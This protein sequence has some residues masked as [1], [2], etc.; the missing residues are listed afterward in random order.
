MFTISVSSVGFFITLFYGCTSSGQT[1]SAIPPSQNIYSPVCEKISQSTGKFGRM[2]A[3][4]ARLACLTSNML[5]QLCL[6]LLPT[7]L[8]SSFALPTLVCKYSISR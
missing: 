4:S 8:F 5:W 7:K 6:Q 1:R 2:T 3:M